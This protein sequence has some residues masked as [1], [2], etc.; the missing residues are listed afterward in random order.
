MQATAEDLSFEGS[1]L[2]AEHMDESLHLLKDSRGTLFPRHIYTSIEATSQ[3]IPTYPEI[4]TSTFHSLLT[5]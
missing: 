3:E 2:F 1:K 5:I 4:L